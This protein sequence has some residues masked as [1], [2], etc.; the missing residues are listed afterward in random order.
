M[1]FLHCPGFL[2]LADNRNEAP[3]SRLIEQKEKDESPPRQRTPEQSQSRVSV[4]ENI[5][6]LLK[7][8]VP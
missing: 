2:R 3:T 8:V 5:A 4:C 1:A 7:L 6:L